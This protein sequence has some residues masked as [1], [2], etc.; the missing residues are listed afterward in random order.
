MANER[1]WD[2]VPPVLL[3]ADGVTTGLIQ[4]A[5]TIGFYFGMQATISN[6]STETTVFIKTVID[7][8][9][10]WVGPTKSAQDY[11]V[12]LSAYT[13]ASGSKLSAMAQNKT[14][15]PMEARLQATYETDPVDAWRVKHVDP[16]G[17]AYT[18]DNPFPVA[19]DGTVSIG[20]V[21][22]IGRAPD[23]NELD[24]NGDGSIN[25]VNLAQL[26]PKEFNEI[27]LTNSV[28]AGQTVPTVVTYKLA[29]S[30]VAT[31][32]LTY[33]GSANLLSV[34]RT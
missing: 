7:K 9:T 27:D 13:V 20:D 12:D 5:D 19:F 28:I 33:D 32:T 26:V 14:S 18:N 1:Q 30:I 31:L 23:N 11:N 8:N 2:A 22:I 24:V 16:Y 4:V 3:T 21:H 15:V 29:S 17:K 6:N 34:V 25:T 10:L